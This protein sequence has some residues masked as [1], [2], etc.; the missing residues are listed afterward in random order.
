M[1]KFTSVFLNSPQ[2]LLPR[3]AILL[4]STYTNTDALHWSAEEITAVQYAMAHASMLEMVKK[5]QLEEEK[6]CVVVMET[7][8]VNVVDVFPALALAIATIHK[9]RD[10]RRGGGVI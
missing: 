3:F 7:G 1:Y 4:C 10:A 2:A 8:A 6:M 9:V 5:M